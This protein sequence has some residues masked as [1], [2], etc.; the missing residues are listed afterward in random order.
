MLV[1]K[2]KK[3]D[4]RTGNPDPKDVVT[5]NDIKKLLA[6]FSEDS[7]KIATC[8]IIHC[9]RTVIKYKDI[10]KAI[11]FRAMNSEIF[12]NQPDIKEKLEKAQENMTLFEKNM[13]VV[14]VTTEEYLPSTCSCVLC[15]G[16]NCVNEK[17]ETWVPVGI[18]LI[19]KEAIDNIN[20]I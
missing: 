16:M 18:E 15:I 14:Q 10:I 9:N 5:T 1:K 8:Y 6:V 4:M 2:K 7:I 11:R 13:K 19:I 20:L 3:M 17:W 12:W